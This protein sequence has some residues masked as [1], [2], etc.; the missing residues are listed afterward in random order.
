[1]YTEGERK[2]TALVGILRDIDIQE[3]G[4]RNTASKVDNGDKQKNNKNKEDGGMLCQSRE[5]NVQKR[6][7]GSLR[8][9][10]IENQ[11][12]KAQECP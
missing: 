6:R 12:S 5:E 10:A 3:V 7:E 8:S 9:K 1:M 4:K 2:K 11:M